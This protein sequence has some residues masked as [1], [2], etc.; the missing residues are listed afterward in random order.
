MKLYLRS[1][2]TRFGLFS[3]AV[4]ASDAVVATAFGDRTALLRRLPRGG[5]WS[6]QED[7]QRGAAARQ[8]V[9]EYSE[10]NRT[11]FDIPLALVGT[12]FQRRVWQA[13][14]GIPFG[15]TRSYAEIA[16]DLESSPRAVGNAN[17]R[18][19]ICLLVPCHRVIGS[20]GAMAGFAFGVRLKQELLQH[21]GARP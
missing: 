12:E 14:E 5:E 4:N 10:G 1:F 19:P 2:K 8:Q 7:S 3:V 13:L 11:R 18:N 15:Q 9:E 16:R 6:P 21:E 17:G 20:D